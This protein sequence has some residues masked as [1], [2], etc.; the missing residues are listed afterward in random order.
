MNYLFHLTVV[1]SNYIILTVSL[2]LL[3][4][5]ARLQSLAHP[6]FA[7]IGAY[8]V[9]ILTTERSWRVSVALAFGALVGAAAAYAATYVIA[10][11]RETDSILA[12]LAILIAVEGVAQ[13]FTD[14][15][16]G[17][18]G[19]SGIPRL[20][21]GSHELVGDAE[22]ACAALS[23]ALCVLGLCRRVESSM[24]ARTLEAVR[25]DP[26]LAASQGHDTRAYLAPL[27]AIC[28][29]CAAVSGAMS[30]TYAGY[31]DPSDFGV[32][33][34]VF[35]LAA[36]VAIGRGTAGA[37]SGA[38]LLAG[39]SELLRLLSVEPRLTGHLHFVL[40]GGLLCASTVR[41]AARARAE[42]PLQVV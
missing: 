27:F 22:F 32:D 8:S 9:A 33:Q 36:T 10:A 29:A 12:T 16:R 26:A 25:A 31:V 13:N 2:S 3:V 34:A 24:A 30:A 28:A 35:V 20:C 39:T 14:L 7:A 18:Y 41:R 19:I 11:M 21:V 6:A 38:I 4:E 40:L 1:I 23:I 5:K 42:I 17:I 37:L 15:T